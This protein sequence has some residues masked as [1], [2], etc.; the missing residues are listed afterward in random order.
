M[1]NPNPRRIE[2]EARVRP[3]AL[4][5]TAVYNAMEREA[6]R[7]VGSLARGKLTAPPFSS[8]RRKMRKGK[9]RGKG[10]YP[11]PLLAVVEPQPP[12]V[13]EDAGVRGKDSSRA[14]CI[15]RRGE[16]SPRYGPT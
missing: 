11:G 13:T 12:A 14:A 7:V 9:D 10:T 3:G 5:A 4:I 6:H 1:S 8:A 2:R 16:T 15:H